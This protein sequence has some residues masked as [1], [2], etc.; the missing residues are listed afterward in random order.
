MLGRAE[1]RDGTFVVI[2]MIQ[3]ADVTTLREF[4]DELRRRA[5]SAAII[6]GSVLDGKLS[7]VVMLTDDLVQR[8]WDA[9]KIGREMGKAVGGGGGGRTDVATGGGKPERAQ[10]GFA[11][12]REALPV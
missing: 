9:A 3:D 7:Y 8:G 1:Q 4:G 11:K 2:E 5:G 10:A 12:A 6:L